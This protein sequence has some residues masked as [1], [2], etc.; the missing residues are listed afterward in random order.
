MNR[1][2]VIGTALLAALAAGLGRAEVPEK[3]GSRLTR[4]E[5]DDFLALHNA[6]RKEVGAGELRWS[7]DLA[8]F[9]QAWADELART[10]AFKHRPRA[11]G[12]FRQKYGENIALMSGEGADKVATGGV[13]LW[14]AEKGDY[15][16]GGA[17]PADFASFKAGHYTQA[18][19]KATKLV[20]AG[21]AQLAAG[22]DKGAWVLVANY[23]PPGNTV[24][25]RPY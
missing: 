12:A 6:A 15:A 23:D 1:R 11:E 14:L 20:G 5:A 24:G 9:A 17:I 13:K 22:D 18:V 3:T 7:A 25:A 8:A 2:A 21:K 16:A 4:A 19:W 10:G